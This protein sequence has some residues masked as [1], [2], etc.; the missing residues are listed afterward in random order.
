[1][2]IRDLLSSLPILSDSS[3]TLS[4]A[5]ALQPNLLSFWLQHTACLVPLLV[6]GLKPRT[7]SKLIDIS[8]QT[9][10]TTLSARPVNWHT[11]SLTLNSLAQPL[12][13]ASHLQFFCSYITQ[14]FWLHHSLTILLSWSPALLLVSWP[15]GL[16]ALSSRLL[17]LLS[18]PIYSVCQQ[19]PVCIL[20]ATS[21]SYALPHVYN[22]PSPYFR[23]GHVTPS[24]LFLYF[25]I[26]LTF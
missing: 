21:S 25:F 24:F 23:S 19:G 3:Y 9:V 15:L 8:K 20:A 11:G 5:P 12:S 18:C 13:W 1:M 7:K 2:I 4:M 14:P 10:V 26:Q 22:N 16:L 6:L 17:S